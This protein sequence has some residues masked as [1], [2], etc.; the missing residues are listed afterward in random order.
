MKAL[1]TG[2]G[3][4]GR[5]LSHYLVEEQGLEV[6]GTALHSFQEENL[7][8]GYSYENCDVCNQGLL[9]ELLAKCRPDY[10][11]HLAA[12][13]S[14]ARS[15]KQPQETME[16]NL[17]GLLNLLEA[18]RKQGIDPKILIPCSS[19]EYGKVEEKDI[20]ITEDH[21]LRPQN[22]YALSKLFQELLARQYYESYKTYIVMTRAFNH[23]G[24][25]QRE[26]FVCSDFAKQIAEAE[27]GI[28]EPVVY[29]GNLSARRD[30]TDV[31]DIVRA[32][33]LVINQGKPGET[34]NVCSERAYAI[35]KIL[36]I[37]L[38]MTK[39]AIEVRVD[40]EKNRPVDTPVLV[41]DASK[42]RKLTGWRPEISF[43][44]T[45][46]D[47]LNYWRRKIGTKEETH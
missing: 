13:S 44:K 27:A 28:R 36:D 31:R 20:P 10:I 25:G 24:P 40:P 21:P 41:G 35:K 3:F 47:V 16:I 17:L 37:L 33:W 23:T 15:W 6:T 11:F 7:F 4:V 22:P 29:V 38:E 45:L 39:T 18:V 43:E 2:V 26:G 42:I 5:H 12:Q 14:V 9:E 19:D 1:I 34:Y 32:Y 8:Q 30:F 46:E